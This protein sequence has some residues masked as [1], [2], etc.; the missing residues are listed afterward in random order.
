MPKASTE[1]VNPGPSPA[2]LWF[3][4]MR[5]N[6]Y[7]QFLSQEVAF[8]FPSA[9]IIGVNSINRRLFFARSFS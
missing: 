3:G 4:P 1:L 7:G 6:V 8:A 9:Q 2:G 5:E